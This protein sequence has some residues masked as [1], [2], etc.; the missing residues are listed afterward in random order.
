MYM[1]RL[2]ME[3]IWSNPKPARQGRSLEQAVAQS[4]QALGVSQ[5]WFTG[6]GTADCRRG[7]RGGSG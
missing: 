1:S 2:D 6:R 4:C 7:P 5:S 3:P